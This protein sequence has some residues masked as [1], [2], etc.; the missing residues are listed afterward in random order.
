MCVAIVAC[1]AVGS[2]DADARCCRR[3]IIVIARIVII[4][5]II[6]GVA[7]AVCVALTQHSDCCFV[8]APVV[9]IDLSRPIIRLRIVTPSDELSVDRPRLHLERVALHRRRLLACLIDRQSAKTC[10]CLRIGA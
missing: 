3:L 2:G 8:A 9:E 7:I 5:V 1:A 4:L 10:H 6:F